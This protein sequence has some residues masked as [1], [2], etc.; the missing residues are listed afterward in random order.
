MCNLN[1]PFF[2]DEDAA[3]NYLEGQRWPNGAVCVH[4]GAD[5]KIYPVSANSKKKVR[6]GLYQC[7]NCDQQFTVTVGTVFERSKVPLHKW[8]MATYLLCSSKKGI[9]TKQIE[10]S[11]G[12]TYKTAWFMTHR[13]REAM[14]ED[15]SNGFFN[16]PNKMGGNGST[17]EADETYI[18]R[19]RSRKGEKLPAGYAHK[20]KV[21]TLVERNG[22]ARSYHVPQVNA[23]TLRP[24]LREQVHA[25]TKVFTDDAGV[26]KGTDKHFKEHQTVNHTDYEYVRGDV[27]TNTIEGYFSILKR[28]LNGVYQ[29]VSKE[30]LKRYLSE[31][32]FRYTYRE[33]NG[34]DDIQRTNIALKG[35]EG[36]RLT[37][38]RHYSQ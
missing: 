21:F 7:N 35:I 16:D 22:R 26:Y 33:K 30:H 4:C 36:K 38:A 13:I 9:S 20:E 29:H 19:R 27:H 28:G 6:K 25:N 10:R 18:G 23:R 12:V 1:A 24:I 2:N 37:Y 32:D 31:F 17:V 8:L 11:L 5:S 15:G 14:R 3:R 34:Y